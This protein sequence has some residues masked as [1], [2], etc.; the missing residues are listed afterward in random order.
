[1]TI[2]DARSLTVR[3]AARWLALS[4]ALYGVFAWLVAFR[5]RNLELLDPGL[6]A[7][8]CVATALSLAMLAMS[9]RVAAGGLLGVARVVSWIF[10]LAGVV[11]CM[12]AIS[13]ISHDPL[14]YAFICGYYG[15]IAGA[16]ARTAWLLGRARGG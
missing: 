4:A 14:R 7:Y 3:S 11:G 9:R 13:V 15:C 1:M 12:V 8:V 16:F 5:F 6:I 2:V 10:A